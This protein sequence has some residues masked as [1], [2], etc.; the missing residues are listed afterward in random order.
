GVYK[1]EKLWLFSLFYFITFGSFVA[2]TV[3]LPS[4]LVDFFALDK[5]DAGL[6]TAGFIF[7]ATFVRPVGGWLADKFQPLFLLM[8]VFAGLTIAAI[9]LAFSPAIGLYTVGSLLIAFSAGIGNGVIFKL[10]PLYFNKQAGIA[11]GIVSMMDGLGGFFLQLL[12]SVCFSVA[13]LY[14]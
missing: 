5:V 4:F 7:I 3:F 9:L 2:F 8:G 11:N 13:C 6:R 12:L 10:V 1:N 14:Y